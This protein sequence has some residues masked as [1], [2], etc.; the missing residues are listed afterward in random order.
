[1]R[2]RLRLKL[3]TLALTAS[4]FV[5]CGPGEGLELRMHLIRY[6][7]FPTLGAQGHVRAAP[8]ENDAAHCLDLPRLPPVGG[9]NRT[10][11]G[12][13]DDLDAE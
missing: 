1:M 12:W 5:A 6:W 7:R 2:N 9:T 11:D 4:A 10:T 3:A 8:V 13:A